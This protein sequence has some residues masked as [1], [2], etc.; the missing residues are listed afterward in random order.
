[1]QRKANLIHSI[2]AYP[3]RVVIETR[4]SFPEV[5][6]YLEAVLHDLSSL[7]Y[8]IDGDFDPD[9]AYELISEDLPDSLGNE[10]KDDFVQDIVRL[11]ALFSKMKKSSRMRIQLE[12][13]RTNMCRL[14]HEDHYRQRMLCTYRGHG[15]E[16]LDESNVDRS[17]LGKGNNARIVKDFSKV[18]KATAFDVLLL[19]GSKHENAAGGVVHRSP[20][21]EKEKEEKRTRVLLKIDE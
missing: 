4:D 21:I 16:W 18:N 5:T 14:F 1:M 8:M 2:P 9:E 10:G 6:A 19:K 13:V 7:K 3:D 17:G 12:L 15:T 20:P 11:C